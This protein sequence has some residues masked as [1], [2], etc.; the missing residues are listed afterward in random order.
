[1]SSCSCLPGFYGDTGNGTACAEC[2]TMGN[3]SAVALPWPRPTL[4]FWV[5]ADTP[6][7]R[8]TFVECMP[9]TNCFTDYACEMD[10]RYPHEECFDGANEYQRFPVNYTW[11][12][13]CNKDTKVG[14]VAFRLHSTP[15]RCLVPSCAMTHTYMF[16]GLSSLSL[17]LGA[18]LQRVP[19]GSG[20]R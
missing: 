5:D 2:P 12:G 19:H 17:H 18:D 14:G 8:L 11:P 15:S 1:M 10:P 20:G 4:G 16:S 3:C 9:R 6:E 13:F 7:A